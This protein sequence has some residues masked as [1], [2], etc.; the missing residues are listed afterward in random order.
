MLVAFV[1]LLSLGVAL[2]RGGSLLALGQVRFHFGP[3]LLAALVL[4]A[5]VYSTF[6][7]QLLGS[8]L[9]SR[10]GHLIV[11]LVLLAVIWANRDLPGFWIA[12]LGILLNFLVILANGGSMP[13]SIAGAERLGLPTDPAL[14][15][16][17][18]GAANILQSEGARLWFL[19]DIIVSPPFLPAK[20]ISVG[21]AVLAIGA[22]VFCQKVMVGPFTAKSSSPSVA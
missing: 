13:V 10:I 7:M 3:V 21:D 15:H 4:K 14:F 1:A 6:G 22:F 16:Q 11:T 9:W 5:A 17:Q 19:G 20:V 2:A 18:Y 12:G 8:G